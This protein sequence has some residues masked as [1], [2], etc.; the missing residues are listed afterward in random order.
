VGATHRGG[1]GW[2]LRNS[3]SSTLSQGTGLA[4]TNTGDC[5]YYGN[6]DAA[7]ILPFGG[8]Y[9][10]SADS[11]YAAPVGKTGPLFTGTMLVNHSSATAPTNAGIYRWSAATDPNQLQRT[12]PAQ[13]AGFTNVSISTSYFAKKTNF[14]NGLNAVGPVGFSDQASG[15]SVSL[16]ALRNRTGVATVGVIVQEGSDWYFSLAFTQ[17]ATNADLAATFTLNPYQADW[18]A[19]DPVS[20]QLVNTGNPGVAKAARTKF[21]AQRNRG[22][23]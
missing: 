18:Y 21:R 5:N 10:P 19:F 16:A 2:S 11:R 8:T 23:T 4:T 9:T 12:A 15:A 22:E 7:Y 20:N 1:L 3:F 13:A 17:T 14:L 6:S